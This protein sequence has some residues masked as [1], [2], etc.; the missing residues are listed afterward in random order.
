MKLKE[1]R[2][3]LLFLLKML[4]FKPKFMKHSRAPIFWKKRVSAFVFWVAPQ[5]F[6][7][8]HK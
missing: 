6:G 5:A 7:Q 1:Q 8:R 2:T 4:K 3:K